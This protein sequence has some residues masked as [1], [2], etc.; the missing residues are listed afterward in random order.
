MRRPVILLLVLVIKAAPLQGCSLLKP[1]EDPPIDHELMLKMTYAIDFDFDSLFG[2][3]GIDYWVGYRDGLYD[4]IVLVMTEQ[5]SAGY[6]ANVNVAWPTERTEESVDR[7][8]R[9]IILRGYDLEPYSLTYP[10]TLE[11][12]VYDWENVDDL[13]MN[14]VSRTVRQIVLGY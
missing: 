14:G 8:N 1:P 5:E 6:P 4:E 13:M 10:I 12:L 7:L 3:F 11:D 2:S 9:Y